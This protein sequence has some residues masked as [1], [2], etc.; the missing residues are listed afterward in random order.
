MGVPLTDKAGALFGTQCHF[1]FTSDGIADGEF[2]FV[3][4]AALVLPRCL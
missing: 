2:E 4:R 3:Q 1:D